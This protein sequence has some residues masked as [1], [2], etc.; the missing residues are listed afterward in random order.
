M[1]QWTANQSTPRH[2][3]F[4]KH[5]PGAQTVILLTRK[6]SMSVLHKVATTDIHTP[7]YLIHLQHGLLPDGWKGFGTDMVAMHLNPYPLLPT[8]S[9][10]H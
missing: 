9:H 1:D 2:N 10:W 4:V 5:L 8:V 6:Q 7:A 3:D